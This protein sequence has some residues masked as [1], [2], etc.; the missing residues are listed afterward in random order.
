MT[1]QNCMRNFAV[2]CGL[3]MVCLGLISVAGAQ[4]EGKKFYKYKTDKGQMRI[5]DSID[6][7]PEQYRAQAKE[8]TA[9]AKGSMIQLDPPKSTV[10]K[11][12]ESEVVRATRAKLKNWWKQATE[13]K[14][15]KRETASKPKKQKPGA[16][17][18]GGD[19]IHT[20]LKRAQEKIRKRNKTLDKVYKSVD[21]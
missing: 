12:Q 6:K 4:A 19:N 20:E 17:D 11:I 13:K 7:L 21:E 8:K 15:E 14:D 3:F 16:E 18:G 1:D 5:V 9:S 2:S 10:Q